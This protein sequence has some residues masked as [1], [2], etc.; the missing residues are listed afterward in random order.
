MPSYPLYLP[1]PMHPFG[2]P[3]VPHPSTQQAAP[4]LNEFFAAM[5]PNAGAAQPQTPAPST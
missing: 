3:F 2:F 5:F 4:A 1:Y